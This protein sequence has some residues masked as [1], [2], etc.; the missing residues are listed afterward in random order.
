MDGGRNMI[1]GIFDTIFRM[2]WLIFIF[3]MMIFGQ[4]INMV[5]A[6]SNTE[7]KLLYLKSMVNETFNDVV[8]HVTRVG[9]GKKVRKK[10]RDFFLEYVTILP[11]NMDPAD[12]VQ[13]IE[14]VFDVREYH[15]EEQMKDL[16]P[17]ATPIQRKNLENVLEGLYIITY[18]YKMARHY[19]LIAKKTKSY[20]FMFQAQALIPFIEGEM[21]VF[22]KAIE[23]FK[24]G[25]PIGD[26]LGP[27]VAAKI[28]LGHKTSVVVKETVMAIVPFKGRVL[29]IIKAKGPDGTCGKPDKAIVQ[30]IKKQNTT[31]IRESIKMVIMVDAGLMAEGDKKGEIVEGS[32][33]AIGGFGNEKF[34]IEEIVSE[35][36]VPIYCWIVKESLKD[37]ITAMPRE[38]ADSVDLVVARIKKF[39][40]AHTKEGD[41]II[42][43]GIGN[44]MGVGNGGI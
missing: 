23:S 22:S 12:V 24:L 40:L 1:E 15:W 32:G 36:E 27:A 3:V 25:C 29:H 6:A 38:V 20:L 14:H 2:A 7:R 17:E 39:I 37:A 43:V 34:R 28:M 33:A 21:K 30:E 10:I 5:L 35:Y 19:F 16:A 18:L 4:K 42:I 13:K 41:H 8:T 9:K 26:G 11:E 44:T 31:M